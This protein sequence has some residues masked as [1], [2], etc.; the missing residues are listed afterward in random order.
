MPFV[1]ALSRH[2]DTATAIGEV[3]G[4]LMDRGGPDPDLAVLFLTPGHLPLC[5]AAAA[6]V[7]TVLNP[8]VFVGTSAAGVLASDEAVETRPGVSLWAAW[9][10]ERR[11]DAAAITP[12]T[13]EAMRDPSSRD[14]WSFSEL[15][16]DADTASKSVLL[17]LAD[18]FSF[19]VDLLL[20]SLREHYPLM[21][22][23]GGLASAAHSPTGNRFVIG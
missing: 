5:E 12:H 1:S 11:P 21:P 3:I 9:W 18:P 14:G 2:P 16:L 10:P 19:P 7:Q 15:T 17:L 20:P 6:T 13:L 8:S 22:V 23:I 4:Q